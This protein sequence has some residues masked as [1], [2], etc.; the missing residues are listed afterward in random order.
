MVKSEIYNP[1][2]RTS[3][4]INASFKRLEYTRLHKFAKMFS[5][6]LF[7]VAIQILYV[8]LDKKPFPESRVE[9][10]TFTLI[11]TFPTKNNPS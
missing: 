3:S 8:F 9:S 7:I 2:I 1:S 6:S 11:K 5:I 10:K 4:W